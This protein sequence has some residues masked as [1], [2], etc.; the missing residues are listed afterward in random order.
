M[1]DNASGRLRRAFTLVELLVVIG[2]IALLIAILLPALNRARRQAIQAACASNMRQIA[3]GMLNYI[4]D[5]KGIIP[6]CTIADTWPTTGTAKGWFW[7]TELVGQKYVQSAWTVIEQD[8]INNSNP[9]IQL[10]VLS[11]SVF[12][13]PACT[14]DVDSLTNGGFS[15]VTTWPTDALNDRYA[16]LSDYTNGSTNG[17][18]P[19]EGNVDENYPVP[20]VPGQYY[21]IATWYM[22][23]TAIP[24]NNGDL[25]DTKDAPFLWFQ[26]T[27][28]VDADL[29]NAGYQRR[30]SNVRRSA[31][32]ALLL[33]ADAL[34][35]TTTYTTSGSNGQVVSYMPRIAA[36][37]SQ[38]THNTLQPRMLCDGYTNIAYFDGHVALVPTAPFSENPN[39]GSGFGPSGNTIF[40]LHMQ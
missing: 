27:G 3:M 33:E 39:R 2:I 5:N 16:P 32:M 18:G 11:Q 10:P 38:P 7:A 24:G 15:G 8:P 25:G 12:W 9:R 34:D 40:L 13:C 29:H 35:M 4:N 23:F 17:T 30:L 28:T 26:A 6:P 14:Q 1:A 21:G 20:G 36:R 31:Q 19:N 22:P 37:H